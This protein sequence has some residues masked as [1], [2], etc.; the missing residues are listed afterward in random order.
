MASHRAAGP[1]L[2]PRRARRTPSAGTRRHRAPEA[3][4]AARPSRSLSL[5]ALALTAHGS[6]EW[7]SFLPRAAVV[8]A[9]GVALVAPL[10]A[11][12][13]VSGTAEAAAGLGGVR[14]APPV[15]RS[16]SYPTPAFAIGFDVV[17]HA[18]AAAA[19]GAVA[20]GAAPAAP[21]AV[22][23]V[24][25]AAPLPAEQLLALR[26]DA[27]QA[28]RTVERAR[29]DG[30]SGIPP[31]TAPQNGQIDPAEL[32][33]LWNGSEMLRADAAVALAALNAT[34]FLRFGTDLCV[35]DGYRSFGEQVAVRRA[36]PGLAAVPGTSQH[37]WGLA[38]DV[39]GLTGF[40]GD[41]YP[42]LRENAPAFGWDNPEWAREGGSGPNEPWHW[43]YVAGQPAEAATDS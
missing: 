11:P 9:L 23:S 36:K 30:C 12:H 27:E 15:E 25:Q 1:A 14:A 21:V 17:R 35:T 29:L 34:Y 3:S 43:E 28:S 32:C 4:A 40:G 7:S 18:P 10:V 20:T 19:D 22:V 8:G 39:C 41:V 13:V 5:P 38:V 42:W 31:A 2:R 16:R 37:G 33:V 24:P 26:A 6:A